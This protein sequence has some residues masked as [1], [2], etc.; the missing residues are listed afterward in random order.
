MFGTGKKVGL[1]AGE[2]DLGMGGWDHRHVSQ[3]H[4]PSEESD[5]T[6]IGASLFSPFR[7]RPCLDAS[8]LERVMDRLASGVFQT[9]DTGSTLGDC[10]EVRIDRFGRSGEALDIDDSR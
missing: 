9:V 8:A 4:S 2:A 1:E 6:R 3:D 10:A 5:S 7:Q